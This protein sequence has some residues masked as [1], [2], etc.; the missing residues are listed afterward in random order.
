MVEAQFQILPPEYWSRTGFIDCKA[1]H[2]ETKHWTKREKL[3]SQ[4]YQQTLQA[5]EQSM[6]TLAEEKSLTSTSE[7]KD[8]TTN[9]S[10]EKLLLA[11]SQYHQSLMRLLKDLATQQGVTL[12]TPNWNPYYHSI[13]RPIPISELI[14][15]IL[16]DYNHPIGREAPVCQGQSLHMIQDMTILDGFGVYSENEITDEID[17]LSH[18]FNLEESLL[19][20]ASHHILALIHLSTNQGEEHDSVVIMSDGANIWFGSQNLGA[21]HST[22]MVDTISFLKEALKLFQKLFKVKYYTAVIRFK[23]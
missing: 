4:L 2:D 15:H 16:G 14:R 3:N 11:Y 23:I 22:S 5:L 10:E 20:I 1:F 21:Y 12:I 7:A 19:P 8:V 9:E 18:T 17:S 6:T 13:D